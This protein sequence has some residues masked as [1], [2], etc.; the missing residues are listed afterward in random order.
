MHPLALGYECWSQSLSFAKARN[1]CESPFFFTFSIS[2]YVSPMYS[3][4]GSQPKASVK[5]VGVLSDQRTKTQ[6]TSSWDDFP[7]QGRISL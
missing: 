4:M 3:K 6:R 2:A 5:V 7:L 1:R